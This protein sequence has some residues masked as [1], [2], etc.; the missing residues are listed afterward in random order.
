MSTQLARDLILNTMYTKYLTIGKV[1]EDHRLRVEVYKSVKL[2]YLKHFDKN[3]CL[4][5]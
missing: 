4:T 5:E 2:A 3:S 1:H